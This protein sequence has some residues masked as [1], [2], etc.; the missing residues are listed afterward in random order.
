MNKLIFILSNLLV[1]FCATKIQAQEKKKDATFLN[2]SYQK[3]NVLGTDA[4]LK[5]KNKEGEAIKYGNTFFLE[6]G[7]RSDGSRLW[8][9]IMNYPS[10]GMGISSAFFD[11]K[12]VSNPFSIYS[13]F[14]SSIKDWGGVSLDYKTNLGLAWFNNPYDYHK[15]PYNTLT[16]SHLNLFIGFEAFLN[17]SLSHNM[18]LKVGLSF[19]HSSNGKLS[20]PN[21]GLN[22]YGPNFGIKYHFNK[23]RLIFKEQIIPDFEQ[24]E[25]ILLWTSAATQQKELDTGDL[26]RGV[27]YGIGVIG[28]LWQKQISL[29]SSIGGGLDISYEGLTDAKDGLEPSDFKFYQKILFSIFFSYQLSVD[30]FDLYI[31]PGF[32]LHK[33][34]TAYL[35]PFLYERIGLRYNI[36]K[37]LF[38]SISL[39]AYD[40]TVA[41]YVELTL[42]TKI[43][44]R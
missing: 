39:R 20:E 28:S 24:K 34:E 14:S 9:Q 41:D 13:F 32:Y 19:I 25:E 5:G 35:K 21:D 8:Q 4:F 43:S 16:G 44:I 3:D 42:G 30:R 11:N 38:C 37:K 36:M 40:F 29:L 7:K 6:Y 27:Y 22:Y 15:N 17:V 2:F 1:L 26:S 10:Y 12:E 31:Q 23:E 18:D 33:N